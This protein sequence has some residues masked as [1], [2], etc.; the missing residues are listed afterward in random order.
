[1]S[2][3]HEQAPPNMPGQELCVACREVWPCPSWLTD[4]REN[5]TDQI[6]DPTGWLVH[7]NLTDEQALAF[8]ADEVLHERYRWVVAPERAWRKVPAQWSAWS[9]HHA[10][11]GSRG[12]FVGTLVSAEWVSDH[13]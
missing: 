3:V 5:H 13:E 9:L 12:S 11:P 6:N 10:V 4:L 1:M 7:A 2:E 8:V